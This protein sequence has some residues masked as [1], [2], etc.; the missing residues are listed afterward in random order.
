MPIRP[1]ALP[2]DLSVLIDVIPP[3]FQY[4]ENADWSIQHDEAESF[5]DSLDG[6]RRIW[7]LIRA[8][9]VVY[10]PMRDVLRGYIWE[11]DG[12]AVGV[13]NVLRRGDTD[14]WVIG[15]VSV[16]PEYRRRGIARALVEASVDYAREHGATRILLDVVEGNTPAVKLYETLGFERFSGES[17][18][19]YEANGPVELV[20]LPDDYALEPARLYDWRPPYGLAQRITPDSVRRYRPVE[21]GTFR[22][23]AV[24][25]PFLPLIF[26]AVGT[27]PYSFRVRRRADEQVVAH[28]VCRVRTR[29]GGMNDIVV[30]LDPAHGAI[31]PALVTFALNR[32]LAFAPGRRVELAVPHW[33]RPTINAALAAG[34]CT[35]FDY[36][37]MGLIV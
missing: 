1:F 29:D 3:S 26:R 20:P 16:L 13:S 27:R 25:R 4:P 8:V 10:A 2:D 28:I 5:V 36:I 19:S 22:Q 12:Q 23:P 24:L 21:E 14:Q 30:V 31:A 18:L 32:A 15:N 9:Q 17:Q 11:E 35:R 7:P 37:S 34:F 33:Q 6:I